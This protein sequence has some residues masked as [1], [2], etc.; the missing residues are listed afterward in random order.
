MANIVL[1]ANIGLWQ[2]AKRMEL[3]RDYLAKT[4]HSHFLRTSFVCATLKDSIRQ[5]TGFRDSHIGLHRSGCNLAAKMLERSLSEG[6]KTVAEIKEVLEVQHQLKSMETSERTIDG[7]RSAV[8][9]IIRCA[10]SG[11]EYRG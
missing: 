9:G 3:S 4:T 2:E 6:E 8:A 10:M 5:V 11:C 7:S 1:G